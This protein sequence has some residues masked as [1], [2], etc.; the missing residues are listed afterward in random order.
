VALGRSPATLTGN[1]VRGNIASSANT[2]E[3]GGLY[4]VSCEAT[5]NN[6]TI[7][8]NVAN[9]GQ[10]SRGEGGGLSVLQGSV[11]I[12]NRNTIQGNFAATVQTG[13]GGGLLVDHSDITLTGNQIITNVATLNPG[14]AGGG[15]GLYAGVG[16]S[17][18][19]TNNVVAG[20]QANTNADGLLFNGTSGEPT[21]G[22][23]LH[24]TIADNFGSG[25]GVS[26]ANFATLAL[27]NTIIAGHDGDGIWAGAS[28]TVTLQATLWH[29][30]GTDTDGL[31]QIVTGTVNVHGDPAFVDPSTWDYH[32]TSTSAAIDEGVDAGVPVDMNGQSRP[33]GLGYDIG[34]DEYVGWQINLPLVLRGGY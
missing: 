12:L 17:I 31:G 6:N 18:T 7:T 2:G 16:T 8:A 4:L 22:R 14:A 34:A 10:T 9:T 13:L 3:G 1:T 23:L 33:F 19:L 32:L 15:G 25:R 20:N 28:T 26:V 5:L 21:S 24:T 11:A 30:N 27:T 29:D